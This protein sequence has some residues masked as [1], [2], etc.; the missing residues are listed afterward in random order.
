MDK[1]EPKRQ[2]IIRDEISYLA[3]GRLGVDGSFLCQDK[4]VV[5]QS[6]EVAANIFPA[7]IG[8]NLAP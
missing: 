1:A 4:E 3:R 2:K 7:K 6:G 8:L 5:F